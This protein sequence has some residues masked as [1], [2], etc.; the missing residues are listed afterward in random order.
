VRDWK[1][2]GAVIEASSF[3]ESFYKRVHDYGS[4]PDMNKLGSSLLLLG[5]LIA[6]LAALNAAWQYWSGPAFIR[7]QTP[8]L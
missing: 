6:F 8:S 1:Q 4:P 5:S 2:H 3:L 7:G